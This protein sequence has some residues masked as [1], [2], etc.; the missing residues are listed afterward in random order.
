MKV[1]ELMVT[2]VRERW[3]AT[4]R[5][6]Y[7]EMLQTIHI[8]HVMFFRRWL[9]GSLDQGVTGL[10]LAS[11][12]TGR[13]LAR[14]SEVSPRSTYIIGVYYIILHYIYIYIYIYMY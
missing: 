14:S 9:K 12:S 2:P 3:V 11:S 13:L 8:D 5:R 1:V 6:G 7:R 4:V 10:S